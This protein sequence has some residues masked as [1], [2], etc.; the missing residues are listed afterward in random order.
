M[1]AQYKAF[2]LN[3][4]FRYSGGN[5]VMNRTRMDLLNMKFQNNGTEILGRW[6]SA[7]NPGD[8]WTPKLWYAGDGFI[9]KTDESSSRWVEK[10]DFIKLQTLTIGYTVPKSILAIAGIRSLRI[11]AQGQDFFMITKY[12]GIDPEISTGGA[13]NAGVDFGG[14]YPIARNILLGISLGL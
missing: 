7:A 12:T 11:F 13:T 2:D 9:N 14:N 3:I 8:G 1:K 6:Q 10:G 4:M 5:K